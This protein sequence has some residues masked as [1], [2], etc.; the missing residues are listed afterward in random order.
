M[1]RKNSRF[2]KDYRAGGWRNNEAIPP[3]I[4]IYCIQMDGG[5]DSLHWAVL[6]ERWASL[7]AQLHGDVVAM[8]DR[9][10]ARTDPELAGL[11]ERLDLAA[12]DFH[13]KPTWTGQRSQR[14]EWPIG[15]TKKAEPLIP[16]HSTR[17]RHSAP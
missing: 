12:P 16:E 2:L 15:S 17:R 1:D 7:R 10:R 8:H 11:I 9:E 3:R 4:E 13:P 6:G 14:A 5:Y